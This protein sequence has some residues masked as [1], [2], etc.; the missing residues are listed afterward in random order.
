MAEQMTCG[1]GLA[2]NSVLPTKAGALIEAVAEVLEV[3]MRALDQSDANSRR[4]YEA[5]RQLAEAHRLA[6]RR[7]TQLG[8]EMAGFRDLPM[9]RHNMVAMKAPA[10]TESFRRFVEL[11]QELLILLQQRIPRD[12]ELLGGM[13]VGA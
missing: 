9:G 4:E 6:G 1:Q 8:Q 7:L 11:E 2:A 3:H 12:R 13:E 10:V 5:Y